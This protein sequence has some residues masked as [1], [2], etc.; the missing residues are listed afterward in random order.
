MIPIIITSILIFDKETKI[1]AGIK[2]NYNNASLI[3]NKFNVSYFKELKFK[4]ENLPHELNL[5]ICGGEK[6]FK[7]Q[8]SNDINCYYQLT[9]KNSGTN[10]KL[11]YETFSEI[12]KLFLK[13]DKELNEHIIK[14][15]INPN[16]PYLYIIQLHNWYKI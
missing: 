2:T 4:I 7:V 13:N 9:E 16:I 3:L 15:N 6:I 11:K 1:E 10:L 12:Q 14:L 5:K 8:S